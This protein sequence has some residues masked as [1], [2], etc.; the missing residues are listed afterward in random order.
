MPLFRLALVLWLIPLLSCQST[1]LRNPASAGAD[2]DPLL[3]CSFNIQFL[4][5]Y[6]KRNHE[7]LARILEKQG[8]DLVV[9]Q[10]L[11][12]PPDLTVLPASPYY[13]SKE[14]PTFPSGSPLKPS[15]ASTEFF[16]CM[17]KMGFDGFVLSSEDTGRSAKNHS[18]SSST[19]WWVV[20]YKTSKVE[21]ASDLPQ[22]FLSRRVAANPNWER[23]PY[24]FAFRTLDKKLD[25]VLISVHL[26]PDK[27]PANQSRR[28]HELASIQKWI[29]DVEQETTERDFIILG[30]MN[31][32]S[33]SELEK[34]IPQGFISLNTDARFM[35]N[36]NV[37]G[38]LPYDHVMLRHQYTSEAPT[39]DNFFVF[40]L[41]KLA[42]EF[43]EGD[44]YPGD[45]TNYKHDTFRTHFSDHHPV[46]FHLFRP[47]QDDD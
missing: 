22:G 45:P 35:T 8:C 11:V 24:A 20:F 7:A 5:S 18:N 47:D 40:D 13:Q 9:V 29:E 43:W 37:R 21:V 39:R 34:V 15:P 6:K 23:V 42:K 1:G 44:D 19:E 26:K 33:G 14:T 36:T 31:I 4:G 17:Y 3:V 38:Q 16:F 10:E 25:F 32:Y 2:N 28:A 30:D 46:G 27:G 41:L 12:A